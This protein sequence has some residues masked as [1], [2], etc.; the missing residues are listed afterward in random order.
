MTFYKH[1]KYWMYDT[2]HALA[3]RLGLTENQ[4]AYSVKKMKAAGVLE[5][6]QFDFTF[7]VRRN[8]YAINFDKLAELLDERR[9]KSDWVT[10][11]LRRISG[12]NLVLAVTNPIATKPCKQN[13]SPMPEIS[14]TTSL[15][16]TSHMNI[17]NNLIP[18]SNSP[19]EVKPRREDFEEVFEEWSKSG[20]EPLSKQLKRRFTRRANDEKLTP[21]KALENLQTLNRSIFHRH[22]TTSI[23]RV[24]HM[25]QALSAENAKRAEYQKM[26]RD[27]K[28]HPMLNEIKRDIVADFKLKGES[29]RREFEQW[30]AKGEN[31][32]RKPENGFRE[33]PAW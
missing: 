28:N 25:G 24:F 31:V 14:G 10:A 16:L 9:L 29:E 3:D 5:V 22:T 11:G 32:F 21:A 27:F 7:G 26:F 18:P 19:L 8:W 1:G 30:L 17:S 13:R 33:R 15:L 20:K 6:D 12:Q 23:N 2:L 4:V